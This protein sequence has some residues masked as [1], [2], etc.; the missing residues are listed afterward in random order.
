[1]RA[2]K[3]EE[4]GDVGGLGGQRARAEM[5]EEVRV[6]GWLGGRKRQKSFQYLLSFS[7]D[8]CFTALSSSGRACEAATKL[9]ERRVELLLCGKKQEINK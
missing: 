5:S 4:E 2:E 3:S 1:M 7:L 6:E 9:V 8:A